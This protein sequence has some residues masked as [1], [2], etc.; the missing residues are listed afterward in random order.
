MGDAARGHRP[1]LKNSSGSETMFKVRSMFITCLRACVV[2]CV[3][4]ITD[5]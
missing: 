5:P 2:E 1:S 4:A 3:T